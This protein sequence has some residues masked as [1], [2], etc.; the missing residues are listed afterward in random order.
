MDVGCGMKPL[1]QITVVPP[2]S[3]GW[4][5]AAVVCVDPRGRKVMP[6]VPQALEVPSNRWPL[7]E[8]WLCVEFWVIQ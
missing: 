3:R 1:F 5:P 7:S 4:Q 8:N 6:V 2:S